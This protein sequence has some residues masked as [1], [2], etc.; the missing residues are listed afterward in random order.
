MGCHEPIAT[1]VL[2]SGPPPPMAVHCREE[3]GWWP[4]LTGTQEPQPAA[5][6]RLPESRTSQRGAPV[7]KAPLPPQG[8]PSDGAPGPGGLRALGHVAGREL[9]SCVC[10]ATGAELFS[11]KE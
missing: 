2:P 1:A 11:G 7:L 6:T 8:R 10:C 3:A 4:A 9:F 5:Q